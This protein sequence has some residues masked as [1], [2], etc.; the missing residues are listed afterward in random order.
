MARK[1]KLVGGLILCLLVLIAVGAFTWYMYRKDTYTMGSYRLEDS[2]CK[3]SCK[4]GYCKPGTASWNKGM[5]CQQP[6]SGRDGCIGRPRAL[7]KDGKG[8]ALSCQK[9]CEKRNFCT[10]GLMPYN[11]GMCCQQAWSGKSGCTR[12]KSTRK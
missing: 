2:P 9:P 4:Q 7:A 11:M 8:R 12:P 1:A 5:C 3:G 10:P 6:W